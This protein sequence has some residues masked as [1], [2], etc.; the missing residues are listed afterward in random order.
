MRRERP[1]SHRSSLGRF[2]GGV[3]VVG[4]W[5]GL[6][7]DKLENAPPPLRGYFLLGLFAFG[8]GLIV[9]LI[10]GGIL[11][12]VLKQLGWLSLPIILLAYLAP[13]VAFS[14]HASDTTNDLLGTIPWLAF[15]LIVGF[16]SWFFAVSAR[17]RR[18]S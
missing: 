2:C 17:T 14:W 1:K 13:V 7:H 12:I 10:Y 3:R 18:S 6:H 4:R 15:A 16:V 11:Y 5:L 9:Q 8:G